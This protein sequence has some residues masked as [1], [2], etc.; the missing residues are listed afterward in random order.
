MSATEEEVKTEV[1][2]DETPVV[3]DDYGFEDEPITHAGEDPVPAE[4]EPSA[5]DTEEAVD[6]ESSPEEEVVETDDQVTDDEVVA[7]DVAED[8]TDD[9]PPPALDVG[10]IAGAVRAGLT[11]PEIAEYEG[12]PIGLRRLLTQLEK[13]GVA[14]P[15]ASAGEGSKRETVEE[16]EARLKE[17]GFDDD[18]I[19]EQVKLKSE[20]DAIRS[21]LAEH[22]EYVEQQER[23]RLSNE[24]ESIMDSM[25]DW[26]KELGSDPENETKAQSANREKVF[27][28]LTVLVN[29]EAARGGVVNSRTIGALVKKAVSNA[30][31]A[32]AK[33][34]SSSKTV[35]AVKKRREQFIQKPTSTKGDASLSAKEKALAN[36]DKMNPDGKSDEGDM[37]YGF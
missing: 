33:K 15:E 32:E 12:D 23:Q 5:D 11:E 29:A 14:T 21:E 34:K 36:L 24:V 13:R 20:N 16:M 17:Q 27:G 18:V 22:R 3:A 28:E 26:S 1:A 31:P 8:D 10:L 25:K 35:A 19:A 2:A 9:V 30:L 7:E 6:D 37:E 4:E